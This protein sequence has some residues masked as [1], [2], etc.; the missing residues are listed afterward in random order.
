[1]HAPCPVPISARRM[2]PFALI[3]V[4]SLLALAAG[5]SPLAAQTDPVVYR[6]DKG[7][8]F[9]RGC[10]PPCLCPVMQTG[11][12]R[13]TFLLTH[14]GSDPMF[15][16]YRVDEVNWTVS[17]AGQ[18]LRVTGSGTYRVGGE[19]AVQQQLVL[20]LK[21]GD[22]PVERFDSG[23]RVGGGEFP[24]ITIPISIHGQVCF[25]T[26]FNL[27]ASPVPLS[28]IRTYRLTSQSSYQSGCVSPCDCPVIESPIRGGLTLI[29]VDRG[30][31]FAEFSVTQV[32]WLVSP[33]PT[34]ADPVG[35][36][37]T[38]F[39]T[40]RIEGEVASQ[41]RMALELKLGQDSPVLFDSGLVPGGGEFPRVDIVISRMVSTCLTTAF[42]IHTKPTRMRA[43]APDADA[44]SGP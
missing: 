12:E 20:D 37:V 18:E 35:L 39:G 42:E 25:D 4:L 6:L 33:D 26:F 36:P 21:V 9:Q 24:R 38:G 22:N 3:V 2:R 8:T 29:P 27:T 7:S 43:I 19:F 28:E 30:P 16:N 44:E 41:Q 5:I 11:T 10:F 15:E 23:L 1:M 13:G 14:V 34:G 17:S 31:L 40:Y 32:S